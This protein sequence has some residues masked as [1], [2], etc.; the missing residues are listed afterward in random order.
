MLSSK[1]Y[2]KT[3]AFFGHCT[4]MLFNCLLLLQ[5]VPNQLIS[6]KRKRCI[7][8]GTTVIFPII[9]I[10]GVKNWYPENLLNVF[11]YSCK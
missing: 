4:I 3:E 1:F 6:I 10:F 7:Q 9:K 8:K 5:C 2:K 11:L